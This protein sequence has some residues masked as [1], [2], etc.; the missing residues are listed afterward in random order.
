MSRLI[1]PEQDPYLPHLNRP[2]EVYFYSD[3]KNC[4]LFRPTDSFRRHQLEIEER[5][6]AILNEPITLTI[7]QTV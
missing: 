5:L 7:L 1:A 2:T 3:G 4:K 6:G